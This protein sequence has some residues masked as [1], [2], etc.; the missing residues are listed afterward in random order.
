MRIIHESSVGNILE[1]TTVLCVRCFL[2]CFKIREV[3]PIETMP[4]RYE[5]QTN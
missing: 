1:Y 2:E 4:V 3:I 5:G